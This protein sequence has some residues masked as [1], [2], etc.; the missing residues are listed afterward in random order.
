MIE[1]PASLAVWNTLLAST[2]EEMGVTLWRTG[3]SPNIRERKD[4]SCA[5][6]NA[7]GE[8]VAQA[9]HIPVHLGAMP[10]SISAVSTL[11][12]WKEGDLAIVNDPYLGG[13]HLPDITI[14]EPVFTDDQ[15]IAF[16]ANRAHH[17]DIGGMSA[18]SMPIA[19]E[20]YQ[21]GLII[22][23]LKIREA[24]Q[25]NEP[26][27][28][29]IL[30]NVRTPTER[31]GDFDA[32][33]GALKTGATRLKALAY[34]HGVRELARWM[35]ALTDY[36]ERLTRAAIESIPDGDYHADD[37]MESID[38]TLLPIRTKLTV[39]GD[40]LTVDFT[41][42]AGEQSSSINAVSA[43]TRS[44]VAY[45]VRCLLPTNAPSNAGIFRPIRLLLPESSIVNA[46]PQRAVSAGNVETSQRVTDVILAAFSQALGDRI[47]ASSAGTM[48]NFTFGGLHPNGESFAYY[49]TV[50][51]GAGAGPKGRGESGIQ[52]HMTNTA[53]TP[54]E[55]ME[56]TFPVRVRRFELRENSGGKGLH[57]G[58]EGV[59]REI[60]F[61]T[62]ANV[63][64]VGDRRLIGPPGA[65]GGHSGKKAS[66]T[67]VSAEGL[68][69]PVSGQQQI[70]I[71]PGDRIEVQTPGGGGWGA[72]P[73]GGHRRTAH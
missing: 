29:L 46:M 27:L 22:P 15:L 6:F 59:I 45:S 32:Q 23:P 61:L 20:L 36:T 8:L 5:V 30:R 12:P 69:K 35:E 39:T 66:N 62:E 70:Q 63:S 11:A 56:I 19:T 34:R 10:E 57:Q 50:P 38:G 68:R 47:P 33:F 65:N 58:G 48:S 40:L 13:T 17:S 3:H 2:A 53:N 25:L 67:L 72:P 16:V 37:V 42:S 43:V 73:K 9:A 44:A 52:T 14:V 7:A 54:T 49:E 1:S 51:G 60:E 24:G 4:F 71:R 31:R 64:L 41:G 28:A 18:G 26:L 21:E 55:S